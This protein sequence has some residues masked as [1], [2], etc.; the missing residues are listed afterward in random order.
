MTDPDDDS[1]LE[2]DPDRTP[3]IV[4]NP[5]TERIKGSVIAEALLEAERYC[6]DRE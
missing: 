2:G 6:F 4:P 1:D 3:L 5:P